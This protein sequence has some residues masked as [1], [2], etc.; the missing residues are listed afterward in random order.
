MPLLRSHM[1][2]VESWLDLVQ[3]VVIVGNQS[4]D[5]TVDYLKRALR[6]NNVL[7]FVILEDCVNL[8]IL[9]F[10][11]LARSLRTHRLVGAGTPR[12]CV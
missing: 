1:K 3:E 9:E 2:T 6:G 11:R 5:G 12:A 7:F 8:G 4:A 10:P